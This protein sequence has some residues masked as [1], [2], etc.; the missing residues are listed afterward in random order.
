MC[1]EELRTAWPVGRWAG[2]TVQHH[3]RDKLPSLELGVASS[4][5]CC[6]GLLIQICKGEHLCWRQGLGQNSGNETNW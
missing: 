3:L 4:V 2:Q 6:G 5:C 1:I